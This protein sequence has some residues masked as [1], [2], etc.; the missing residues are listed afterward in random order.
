M[1]KI[2]SEKLKISPIL[3]HFKVINQILGQNYNKYYKKKKL[4]NKHL[5]KIYLSLFNKFKFFVDSFMIFL[6]LKDIDLQEYIKMVLKINNYSEKNNSIMSIE[7]YENDFEDM[8]FDNYQ[9]MFR[10]YVNEIQ[11]NL[12][13]INN[14]IIN[15]NFINLK[16]KKVKFIGSEINYTFN[17]II[18]DNS[19]TNEIKGIISSADL[20][21]YC[22][23]NIFNKCKNIRRLSQ[24]VYKTKDIISNND[25][26]YFNKLLSKFLQLTLTD[27]FFLDNTL[28]KLFKFNNFLVNYFLFRNYRRMK[29][30]MKF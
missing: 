12:N 5:E 28:F 8:I 24:I 14:L 7:K 20:R 15:R 22:L 9:T 21:R 1:I 29:L 19:K 18:I 4:R 25:E 27:L 13:F 3:L 10:L 2:L 11:L 16:I 17:L 6:D 26:N 30:I 23:Q